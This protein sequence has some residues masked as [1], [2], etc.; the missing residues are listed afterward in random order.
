MG[1]AVLADAVLVFHGLFSVWAAAGAIAVWRW[2]R[3]VWLHLPALA[4]AVWIEASGGICPLT[5]LENSLRRAAG[6]SG[7][8]GGFIDHYLGEI[9]YPNGLTRET[10]W[11]IACVLLAVN[12]VAYLLIVRRARARRPG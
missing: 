1:P 8:S 9:I 11:V 4:W 2:P 3:L 12:V 7:Y 5:P 10:Q 6:Q